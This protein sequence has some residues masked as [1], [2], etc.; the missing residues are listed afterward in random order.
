MKG[1]FTL[2]VY[3]VFT[4]FYGSEKRTARAGN[5]NNSMLRI[6]NQFFPGCLVIHNLTQKHRHTDINI[7]DRH[8]TTLK[9]CFESLTQKGLVELLFAAKKLLKLLDP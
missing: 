1:L 9:A 8:Y 2:S 3:V 7:S 6:P 4:L 5:N